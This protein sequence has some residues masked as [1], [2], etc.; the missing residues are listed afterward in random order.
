MMGNVNTQIQRAIS[1]AISNQIVPQIQTALNTGSGHLTQNMW[2]VSSERPETNS[3][4]TYSENVKKNTRCEPRIDYRN[5]GHVQ[6]R[7]YDRSCGR[8]LETQL[9]YSR[10]KRCK[11][12]DTQS[13]FQISKTTR[14]V[15]ITAYDFI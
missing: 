9:L 5:D 6:P 11:I 10:E 12:F 14:C 2:N 13:L 8:N 15:K 4:E 7:A 1:D 3:E